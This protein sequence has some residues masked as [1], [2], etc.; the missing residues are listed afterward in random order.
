[1]RQTGTTGKRVSVSEGPPAASAGIT[2][3]GG[4]FTSTL[5]RSDGRNGSSHRSVTRPTTA[6][7]PAPSLWR[8]ASDRLTTPLSSPSST[9]WSSRMR[10]TSPRPAA[11]RPL[12]PLWRCSTTTKA[13]T[14]S[15]SSTEIW[16]PILAAVSNTF[17]FSLSLF[18]SLS[19]SLSL[20]L[21][22]FLSFSLL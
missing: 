7:A 22:L 20:S 17:L 14:S 8:R 19:L 2:A 10:A 4:N 1:M 5:N 3:A 21:F 9:T 12:S 6:T 16:S 13:T 15:S 18:L 11:Y